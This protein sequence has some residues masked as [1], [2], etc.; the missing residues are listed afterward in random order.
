MTPTR[1]ASRC[2]TTASAPAPTVD[3]A[4]AMGWWAWWL[5]GDGPHPLPGGD[6]LTT[7]VAVA[8][9]QPLVRAGFAAIVGHA[10]DLELV[11]DAA[12]GRDRGTPAD[13]RRGPQRERA[14]DHPDHLRSGR[15]RVWGATG[16]RQRIPA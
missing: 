10:P 2:S 14:G 5:P 7:R 11:G 6:G 1:F 15:V 16:G 8:D 4:Q 13:H 9:D 3:W 12:G